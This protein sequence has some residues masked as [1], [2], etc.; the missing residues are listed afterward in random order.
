MYEVIK[1]FSGSPDG[2]RVIEYE[3]GQK[4][5]V[6]SNFSQDLA[7]VALAEKWVKEIEAPK[8]KASRAKAAKKK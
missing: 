6:C 2:C 7:D 5:E 3:K 1:D 8:P 4:L